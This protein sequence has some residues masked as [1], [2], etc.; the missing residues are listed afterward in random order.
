M[1]NPF[2]NLDW[3]EVFSAHVAPRLGEQLWLSLLKDGKAVAILPLLACAE[4]GLS[5]LKSMGNYYSPY[6]DVICQEE[7]GEQFLRELIAQAGREL[8]NYDII[9]L[10]PLTSSA[11][12]RIRAAF[13]SQ[14]YLTHSYHHTENWRLQKIA[15]F[16]HFWSSRPSQLRS[17]VE[18][19]GKKLKALEHK[20]EIYTHALSDDVVAEYG[21]IYLRSWKRDEP[22]PTFIPA[23]LH[24][25]SRAGTLRLGMLYIDGRPV[26]AQIWFVASATAYIYKLA[27]DPRFAHLSVGSLL[28]QHLF[29]HAIDIDRVTSIDYLTG[30]DA[31]KADWMD[32]HRELTGLEMSS[33]FRIRGTLVVAYGVAGFYARKVLARLGNILRIGR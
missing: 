6:F 32:S 28:S 33:P 24:Q 4:G 20:F 3:F 10:S 16:D 7:G 5:V 14:G 30:S 26:A 15:G 31:Y 11:A 21:D 29:R 18:R 22:F 27:Y 12:R 1:E 23:L 25:A 9:R 8:R 19:K 2:L 13:S 17:T